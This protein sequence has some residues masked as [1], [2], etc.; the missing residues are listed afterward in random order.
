MTTPKATTPEVTTPK[1]TIPTA[2]CQFRFLKTLPTT[3]Y[4]DNDTKKTCSPNPNDALKATE[5]VSEEENLQ[6]KMVPLKNCD[7]IYERK[8]KC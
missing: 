2:Q 4:N 8:K 6:V 3:M 7:V 1:A 5:W